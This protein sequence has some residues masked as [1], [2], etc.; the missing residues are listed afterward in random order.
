MALF[1]EPEQIRLQVQRIIQSFGKPSANSGHIFNLGHGISQFTNPENV[2]VL[3]DAVH[4]FSQKIR[5]D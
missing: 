1:A 3:V 5:A 2:T 4:E